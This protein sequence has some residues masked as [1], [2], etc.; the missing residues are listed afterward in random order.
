MM[1]RF[2]LSVAVGFLLAG[3]VTHIQYPCT[4]TVSGEGCV[5]FEKAIMHPN[6]LANNKQNSLTSF[7][8]TFAVS[9]IVSFTLLS[10]YSHHQTKKKA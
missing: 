4:S 5:S 2:I 6:D 3:A 1:Y 9:T 10:V 7:A 8:E